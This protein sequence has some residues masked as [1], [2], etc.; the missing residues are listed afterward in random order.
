MSV[1]AGYANGTT[2][3]AENEFVNG[4]SKTMVCIPLLLTEKTL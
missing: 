1:L 2:L 3:V 4:V